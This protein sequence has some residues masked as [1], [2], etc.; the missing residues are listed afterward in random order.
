MVAP[1]AERMTRPPGS[2]A[3]RRKSDAA[4]E[5]QC[6]DGRHGRQEIHLVCGEGV[7]KEVGHGVE[8]E[9]EL[10]E[11]RPDAAPAAVEDAGPRSGR[12]VRSGSLPVALAGLGERAET[13]LA[14]GFGG[15]SREPRALAVD[16]AYL[17]LQRW[18][19]YEEAVCDMD[20]AGGGRLHELEL[21]LRGA[22]LGEAFAGRPAGVGLI[23]EPSKFAAHLPNGEIG[24]SFED[25][26]WRCSEFFF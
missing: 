21:I 5:S 26:S 12:Y 15:G 13:V 11:E 7:V 18:R 9:A 17:H 8:G 3:D 16:L 23:F 19:R 2:E 1:P 14:D 6:Q 20:G 4:T 10:R 25:L 22:G 24:V